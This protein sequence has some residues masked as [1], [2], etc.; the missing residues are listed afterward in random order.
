[1]TT[2]KETILRCALD[3][4]SA[5]GFA[6]TSTRSIAV[7]AGVSEGL[8]FRHF[9]T[10]EGLLQVILEE[11]MRE[12]GELFSRVLNI[13]NPKYALKSLLKLP[14]YAKGEEQK[15]WKLLYALK[16]SGNADDQPLFAPLRKSLVKIFASLGYHDPEAEADLAILFIDG[17]AASILL[18][19]NANREDM[20]H[21]LL[22]KYDL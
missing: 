13:E 9:G 22:Q 14:F 16:W 1:M 4:F 8:V 21:A 5:Q 20:M 12:T 15:F 3:L 2:K 18:R 6:A 10:K 7:M 19:E 11:G 17:A